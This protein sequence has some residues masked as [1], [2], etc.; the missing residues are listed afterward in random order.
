MSDNDNLVFD[1][2]HVHE[3]PVFHLGFWDVFPGEVQH[4]TRHQSGCNQ[5]RR[6]TLMH[7]FW[8]GLED[9]ERSVGRGQLLT[10]E[11][12]NV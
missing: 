5:S 8:R 6:R 11:I 4:A 1:L 2:H 9:D 12:V 3:R 10:N 7:F